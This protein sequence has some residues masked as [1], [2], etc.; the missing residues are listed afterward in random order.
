MKFIYEKEENL[1][2]LYDVKFGD[3]F[4]LE[5]D[6]DRTVF[7]RIHSNAALG[8]NAINLSNGELVYL[9]TEERIIPVDATLTVT[10]P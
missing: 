10:H 4:L 8:V 1:L 5:R 7:M 3:V 6:L 9:K 2:T